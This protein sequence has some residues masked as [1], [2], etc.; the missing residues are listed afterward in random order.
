MRLET[1]PSYE[2]GEEKKRTVCVCWPLHMC[3]GG[4]SKVGRGQLL[5]SRKHSCGCC[6]SNNTVTVEV[7]E[8]EF[9]EVKERK[10]LSLFYPHTIKPTNAYCICTV[11]A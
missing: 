9:K 2:E 4:C 6:L 11:N 8:E 1:L 3:V 7:K 5:L 10:T